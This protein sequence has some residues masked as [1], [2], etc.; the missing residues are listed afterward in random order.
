MSSSVFP[1]SGAT[2]SRWLKRG[3]ALAVTHLTLAGFLLAANGARADGYVENGRDGARIKDI[4]NL[5]GVRENQLVGYGLVVGLNGTG[6]TLRNSPFTGQSVQSMLDRM[7]IHIRNAQLRTRNVAAVV[8]T[9]DLPP[10]IGE[11]EKIDVTVSSLGDAGSLQGG[12][13]IV[14]PLGGP[15]GEVYAVAQGPVAVSGFS[16]KGVSQTVSEGVPTGGRI[17]NGALIERKVDDRFADLTS[18][19]LEL[20]NPD[21]RTVARVAD[22]VNLYTQGR[23]GQ[24]GAYER[25]NRTV[26]L[27]RP[28]NIST[29]RFLAEIG[30]L[31]VTPDTPARVVVDERSGTV[32]IGK[33]VTISTV[34][35]T[36]G[37]LTVRVTN[38]PV[39]SQPGPFSNGQTVVTANTNIQ[40]K[41][42]GGQLQVVNGTDLDT[43][44]SGLNQIGLTP[45]GIIS[46]LQTIKTAGAL[47]ADLVVQ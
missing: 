4:T 31:R 7:G 34:A 16:A 20:K 24:H 44:V 30:E 18:L 32:V 26:V 23:F 10:F 28:P 37:S 9:A 12:T 22:A 14:T 27:F 19:V 17:A 6:D 33:N 45:T 11:G 13:L 8:V 42:A 39:V 1:H 5:Q 47:Q 36:H 43:L 35:V 29:T 15:N 2:P 3:L 21:F 25:D 40:A 46:I 38:T 41:Q